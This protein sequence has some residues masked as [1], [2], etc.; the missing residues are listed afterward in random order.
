MTKTLAKAEMLRL[1]EG[2]LVA[3]GKHDLDGVMALMHD[4][5][6]FENWTGACI[7]GKRA[8]RRSW[9]PWFLNHGNFEFAEEDVFVDE[10]EQKL[11]FRWCLRWPSPD[12]AF[13]G[14]TEIRRGVD[15]LHFVD[16]K[17][18]KKYTYSKTTSSIG[19]APATKK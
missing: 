14:A 18:Y 2:W 13:Q 6:V 3:W 4:D 12:A 10:S 19:P 9:T 7:A 1:F 15:V 11:L 8:L 17:I 16:H 5:V